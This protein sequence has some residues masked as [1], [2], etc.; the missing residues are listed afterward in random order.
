MLAAPQQ[1]PGRAESGL[2]L[3]ELMVT[4]LVAGIM[5]AAILG[6]FVTT[7]RTFSTGQV[8][9]QNQDDARL[10]L[11]QMSRYLRMASASETYRGMTTTQSDAIEVA[12]PQDLVFYADLDGDGIVEKARYYLSGTSLR[13]QT[14]EP[15]M[16]ASPPTYPTAFSTTGEVIREGVRNG[17]T[18]LFHYY[19][20]GESAPM[21]STDTFALR[22]EIA[23][24]DLTLYVNEVPELSRSNVR[25]ETRVQIRQRYDGGLTP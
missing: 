8:R 24:V 3:I 21:S 16:A 7:L 20:K 2:S 19:R 15:N 25:L 13:M 18:A 1:D 23:L 22:E 12:A 11:S 9:M 10:A 4:I 14:A 5:A 6:V 17:S